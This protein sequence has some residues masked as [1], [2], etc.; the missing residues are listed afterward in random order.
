VQLPQIA[1]V[2]KPADQ[3]DWD[4]VG[5]DRVKLVRRRKLKASIGASEALRRA[6]RRPRD[7]ITTTPA[8]PPSEWR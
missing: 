3:V 7:S 8:A 2:E 5:A 6:W 1:V 4:L